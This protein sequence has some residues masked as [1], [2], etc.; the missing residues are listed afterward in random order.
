M[1]GLAPGTLPAVQPPFEVDAPHRVVPS[2]RPLA[3]QPQVIVDAAWPHALERRLQRLLDEPAAILVRDPERRDDEGLSQGLRAAW[4]LLPRTGLDRLGVHVDLQ[5]LRA[6][7]TGPSECPSA[8]DAIVARRGWELL[9]VAWGL[10][11]SDDLV[12]LRRAG[13]GQLRAELLSVAFPSGW[14]PRD[15]AGASLA[16]LHAPVADGE[17]LQRA[18]GALSEALLTKGPY[19]QHVW[20]VDRCGRLDQDP[21]SSYDAQP[22]VWHLRVERQTSVPLPGLDR[23]LFTIRPYLT[24]LTDLTPDQLGRLGQALASMSPESL[25]YKGVPVDLVAQIKAG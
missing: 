2:P 3:H 24:P 4:S 13:P 9:A 11:C 15:R 19:L 14:S 5:S 6:E 22:L 17:R 21:R 10:S 23:A 12:V 8:T 20:G 18:T 1:S 16:E 7:Q 25:A